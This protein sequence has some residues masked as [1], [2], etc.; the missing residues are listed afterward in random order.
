MY[1]RVDDRLVH[2]QV[3]TAWVKQ[4]K[5]KRIIVV[6]DGPAANKFVGKALKLAAPSGV[7]LRL[8]T[9]E[10]IA[11]ALT[12][13]TP[14]ILVIAKYPVVAEKIVRSN[15]E[16]AWNVN[17]GNVGSVEGRQTYAD[18]VHLDEEN[19]TAVKAMAA[20]PNVDIYMQTVPGQP[21]NRFPTE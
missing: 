2:G 5:T 20:L 8:V 18:T 17:I 11:G 7:D 21:I 15:P 16:V 1:L 14:Y 9:V 19:Y 6:D 3:V 12:K 4:L 13:D 10:R